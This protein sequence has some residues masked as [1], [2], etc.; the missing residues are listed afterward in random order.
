MA[1]SGICRKYLFLY[2]NEHIDFRLPELKSISVLQNL[3]LKLDEQLYNHENPF[4]VLELKNEEEACKIMKRTI[5]IRSMYELWASAPSH[6]E[7][8]RQLSGYPSELKNPYLRNNMSFRL[9]IDAFGKSLQTTYKLKRIDEILSTLPFKGHVNLCNAENSFH[10]LEH[11][12]TEPP[13]V[14]QCI[15]FGRWIMDGQRDKVRLYHL[16]QR[17]HIGNTS[18]DSQLSLIMANQARV[19]ENSIV[20]D[21]FVGTGS[22]LI[23]AAAFGAYVIGADIDYKVIH[24]RGKSSRPNKKYRGPDENIQANFQQYKL[25][26]NYIGV[27]LAD[28]SKPVWRA[29]AFCDAIITD[30]PYGIREA[31][32]KTKSEKHCDSEENSSDCDKHESMQ[33]KL[34]DLFKD[35]LNFS[36]KILKVGGRLVYW[37]PVYRPEYIE[38]NVPTHSC[39]K[40]ISNSEQILATNISRRLITMEKICDIDEAEGSDAVAKISENHYESSFRQKYFAATSSWDKHSVKASRIV[41]QQNAEAS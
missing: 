34:A 2:A 33:Y 16:Q 18:M 28:A 1:V 12:S 36:A 4:L 10:L 17:K 38:K 8:Y 24:G 11:Y 32:R 31:T 7:L 9:R 39:L 41:N 15:Y 29:N 13:T 26:N 19:Q 25:T 37:L 22:L 14:P 6:D 35:L 40:L 21:P 23:A 3:K 30:P 27:V 20:L 5:L